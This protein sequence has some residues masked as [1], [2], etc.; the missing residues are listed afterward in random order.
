[1]LSTVDFC[2][3]P[4]RFK[5]QFKWPKLQELYFKLFNGNFE[6]AHDAMGDVNALVMCFWELRRREFKFKKSN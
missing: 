5:G 3:I 1:M 2:K 6:D 4:G